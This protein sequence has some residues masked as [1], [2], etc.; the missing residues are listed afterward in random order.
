MVREIFKVEHFQQMIRYQER[1]KGKPVADPFVIARAF[2]LS[3]GCVVT[4]ELLKPNAA[5]IPNICQ[6]FGIDCTDLGG[7][8]ERENWSF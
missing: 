7:F 2:T 3:E 4:T 6:H 8:M 5:K 1:Q